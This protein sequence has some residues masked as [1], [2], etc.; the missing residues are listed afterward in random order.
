MNKEIL[1]K[2]YNEATES[3]TDLMD[4]GRKELAQEL[5]TE[6]NSF[7]Q[8]YYPDY[9]DKHIAIIDDLEQVIFR[10]DEESSHARMLSINLGYSR[11]FDWLVKE[12]A[13]AYTLAFENKLKGERREPTGDSHIFGD[14][15]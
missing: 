9:G 14:G 6:C 15:I 2:L 8:A 12:V 7:L 11:C 4:M 10:T 5:L 3:T 1:I 13:K